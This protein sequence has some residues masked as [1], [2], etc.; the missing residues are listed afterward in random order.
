MVEQALVVWGV[1]L[2]GGCLVE[3]RLSGVVVVGL[4]VLEPAGERL[5]WL[6]MGRLRLLLRWMGQVLMGQVLM[7]LVL[8]GQV[9]TGLFFGLRLVVL[10]QEVFWF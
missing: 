2:L 4:Q 10:N 6:E 5:V 9:L 7:G 8:M 3:L 1:V